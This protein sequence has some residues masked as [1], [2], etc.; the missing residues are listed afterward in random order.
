[1]TPGAWL[2][3]VRVESW[4]RPRGTLHS[5]VVSKPTVQPIL[6]KRG[7]GE[8]SEVTFRLAVGGISHETNTYV[9]GPTRLEDFRILRG[10]EIKS[11]LGPTGTYIGGML[12]AAEELGAT[13]VPTFWALAL[14]SG[15]IERDAYEALRD[16]LLDSIEMALPIDA[17]ALDI[18]G[19]GVAESIHDLEGDLV[20][21]LRNLVGHDVK[22]L[23]TLDLHANVTQLMADTI[24][25]ILPVH[26]Y[27]HTD[28]YERGYEAVTLIP[29]ILSGEIRPICHVERLPM[30]MPTTTTLRG[31]ARTTNELC[32]RQEDRPGMVD[33]TFVHGFPYTDTP[34]VAATVVATANGNLELARASAR[35]VARWVWEHREEFRPSSLMSE[36]AVARALAIEGGP[37]VI[38][39]TSDNPGGGAPG[40]GTHLLRAMVESKLQDA[41]F[42]YIWDAE[43][44]R[45]AHEAGVGSTIEVN[46]GGKF[47]SL[48]GAPLQLSA[49]VKCLTDG[50]FRLR[51]ML[52]GFEERLGPTARLQVDGIDIIVT[53]QRGLQTLEPEV[54]LLHGID[55]TRFKIVA[56]KSSHHFRAGFESVVK[57]IVTADGPGLTT[58]HVEVFERKRTP[59]P[60]WPLDPETT[61]EPQA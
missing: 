1:M 18:H 43:V 23:A 52:K 9:S 54:F 34:H 59:R 6:W 20:R 51:S 56:L 15:T 17:V 7:G 31:P 29:A 25:V 38:N 60:I 53:S 46:L 21:S 35:S 30:L 5:G 27:P 12:A 49:Y 37:I 24:D 47:D 57:E 36:E 11:E 61:Y 10:E 28:T 50:R 33:C 45:M 19:A 55:I 13:S 4:R 40:D 32:R 39:E 16:E 48:H 22:I 8:G 58:L 26:Y 44:A 41:C 14:P 3:I 42:G 2:R